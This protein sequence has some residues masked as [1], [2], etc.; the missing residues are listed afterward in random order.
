MKATRRRTSARRFVQRSVFGSSAV[1]MSSIASLL[2]HGSAKGNEAE[3]FSKKLR[4]SVLVQ[5][6]L[7]AAATGSGSDDPPP[8]PQ[9]RY[10]WRRQIVTTTFWIGEKA[11][12]K[13]PVPNSASS[14]DPRWA[15][16]Y[17]GTDTPNR[18]ERANY[19]PVG[20]VPKLNPFYVA[21]PYND[22]TKGSHKPEASVVIPWFKTTFRGAGVSV[23]KGRWI[24]IRFKDRTA[25]AQWEDCGPF[26]TDH[27]QY[28]FGEQR[29]KPNL[30][31]GAGLDVSPSVRD[32]LGMADTD[33]TD[34]RFVEFSEVP[35]GPW[36]TH[37]ENNTFVI[38][39]RKEDLRL[40]ADNP[41][42]APKAKDAPP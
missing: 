25:Y 1:L 6:R 27:W 23:C 15:E 16:N 20:F 17:G 24:A 11:A 2:S 19:L 40:A 29:P 32:Y 10:P 12:P 38:N 7:D 34:W 4:E 21:L 33:V 42:Q 26:R 37:G 36:S 30:N 5:P 28:V 22:V 18:A 13:N 41:P 39:R 31:R 9:D 14:W 3:K 35:P 8:T